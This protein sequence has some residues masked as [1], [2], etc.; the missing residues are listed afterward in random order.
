MTQPVPPPSSKPRAARERTKVDRVRNAGRSALRSLPTAGDARRLA[1]RE[2]KPPALAEARKQLEKAMYLAGSDWVEQTSRARCFQA[3]LT[4]LET[5][6]RAAPED[7]AVLAFAELLQKQARWALKDQGGATDDFSRQADRVDKRL[8]AVIDGTQHV[9]DRRLVMATRQEALDVYRADGAKAAGQDGAFQKLSSNAHYKPRATVDTSDLDK[10]PALAD[11]LDGRTYAE[12]VD[13]WLSAEDTGTARAHLSTLYSA[14]YAKFPLVV[15]Q[16]GERFRAEHGV[17]AAEAAAITTYSNSDY[18]YMNPAVAG[19]TAAASWMS[20]EA[21]KRNAALY[22][23]KSKTDAENAAAQ[24]QAVLEHQRKRAAVDAAFEKDLKDRGVT[25]GL[26]RPATVARQGDA[27]EAAVESDMNVLRNEGALHSAVALRGL[28]KLPPWKGVLHRGDAMDDE[29]FRTLF[30]VEMP[31]LK[32][33]P[34]ADGGLPPLQKPKAFVPKKGTHTWPHLVSMSRSP[35]VAAG[36]GNKWGHKVTWEVEVLDGREM[37]RLSNMPG[38]LEVVVLPGTTVRITSV[39]LEKGG[40][41]MT[42]RHLPDGDSKPYYRVV[43]KG[44]Q[45]SSV[46]KPR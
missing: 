46:Q 18:E 35:N 39:T 45:V 36:F 19:G 15:A 30:T 33:R 9:L 1:G 24:K 43:V 41:P 26:R 37:A 17:D 22:G 7:E 38:E 10:D 31:F 27:L 25:G 32:P 5:A 8:Q 13:H 16:L 2:R 42:R 21:A 4:A 29:R 3:S 44:H 6:Q 23:D 34:P 40:F 14:S 28:L 11:A 20:G 12:A